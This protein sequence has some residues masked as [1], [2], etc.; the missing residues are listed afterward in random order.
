MSAHQGTF[1]LARPLV[2]DRRAFKL[3]DLLQAVGGALVLAG[4]VVVKLGEPVPAAETEFVEPTP[5]AEV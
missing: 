4:V 3:P 5:L 2:G 1:K